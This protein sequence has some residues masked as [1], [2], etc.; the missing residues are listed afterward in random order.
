[1]TSSLAASGPLLVIVFI[2]GV[3]VGW[4][5]ATLRRTRETIQVSAVPEGT[6][7]GA[8]SARIAAKKVRI[9]ELKCKC[10]TTLKF[11]DPV[12][13]ELPAV[14][15]RRFLHLLRLRKSLRRLRNQQAARRL[16]RLLS[17]HRRFREF[18]LYTRYRRY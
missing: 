4:M 8:G 6:S 9:T 15:D 10:G 2:A 11:G 13:T 16:D 17:A 1:M 3:A 5:L 14:P 18:A 12:E 7:L